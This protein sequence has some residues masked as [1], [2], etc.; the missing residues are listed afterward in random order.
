MSP[1]AAGAELFAN[2]PVR[3]ILTPR[4]VRDVEKMC[5]VNFYG[6]LQQYKGKAYRDLAAKVPVPAV[7]A[8]AAAK[9]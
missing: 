6:E 8:V 4:E 5:G 2:S 1:R 9:L 7:A 3:Q